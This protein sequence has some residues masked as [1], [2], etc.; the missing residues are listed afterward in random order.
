LAKSLGSKG[1]EFELFL[2][3]RCSYKKILLSQEYYPGPFKISTS[4]NLLK[5]LEL[6]VYMDLNAIYDGIIKSNVGIRC[7]YNSKN[8][9]IFK[10][11]EIYKLGFRC[12]KCDKFSSN[13]ST[14]FDEFINS[15]EI[16]EILNNKDINTDIFCNSCKNKGLTNEEQHFRYDVEQA[17]KI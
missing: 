6:P 8:L 9:L 1:Y 15:Q 10:S 7:K 11:N 12:H 16:P 4:S 14:Q 2:E 3:P 17:T 5:P 13:Q